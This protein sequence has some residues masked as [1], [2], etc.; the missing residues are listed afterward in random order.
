[1]PELPEVETIRKDL[2]NVI[3]NKKITNITI[4]KPKLIKNSSIPFFKQKLINQ[5]INQVNRR[6][7]LLYLELSNQNYLLI[8]LKMTGQLIYQH[9]KQIIAG[10]H[11]EPKIESILPNKYSHVIFEFSDQ[12]QLFFNDQRQFGYFKIVEQPEL[13]NILQKFGIEPLR[14]EF[15]SQN[16]TN[17]FA[18][19]T[20]TVK[21]I[22]LNQNAISG[23]GN[24]YADEICFH[25]GIK[26]TKKIPRLTATEVQKLF[27][28]T[29][30]IIKKAIKFRGTTFNNYRDSNG[31]I[32]NFKSQL[33]VYG[34]GNSLCLKCQTRKI[35]KI[36]HAGRG[37]HYCPICQ[38]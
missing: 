28:S 20:T 22:L 35:K 33:M 17:L 4:S 2:S 18:K 5:Q 30:Y 6:G 23:I 31:N 12:S 8:H 7:K 25:A 3:L 13:N 36:K 14:S 15:T 26:P 21:N 24:I 38:K 19:K 11:S 32:G 37:T 16:F 34:R 9:Q 29:K 1:L 27:Q 10:G